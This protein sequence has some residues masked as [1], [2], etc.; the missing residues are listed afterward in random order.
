MS[1][2]KS[3]LYFRTSTSAVTLVELLIAVS[4]A[5]L[6]GIAVLSA[7]SVG[8]K[9]YERA[10]MMN[11]PQTDIFIAFEKLE[12][13][14]K[15]AFKWEGIGFK[16]GSGMISFP[17]MVRQSNEESADQWVIGKISYIYDSASR[18]LYRE[19]LTY[20]QTLSYV[21][22]NSEKL[23]SVEF[24]SFDFYYQDPVTGRFGWRSSWD[25]DE[26]PAGIKIKITFKGVDENIEMAKTVFLSSS[27]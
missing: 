6:V 1:K 3:R 23:A 22:A 21:K 14:I 16:A 25:K 8:F 15:N 24:V 10:Q 13:D 7:F 9:T 12:Q 17:G 27:G 2:I 19:E 18:A 5:A 4:L 11:G 26:M 20:P